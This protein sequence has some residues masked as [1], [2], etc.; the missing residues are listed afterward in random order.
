[1]NPK[2]CAAI[3]LLLLLFFQVGQAQTNPLAQPRL[4]SD[5]QKVLLWEEKTRFLV[6]VFLAPECPLCLTYAPVLR[7]LH[8]QTGT[9]RDIRFVG[10]FSGKNSD[11]KEIR[12]F[13]QEQEVPFPLIADPD[14]EIARHLGATIT[15]EVVVLGRNGKKI[16]QGRIDNRA[17]SLGKKRRVITAYDLQE[18][19]KSLQSGLVP[20]FRKTEA[21]GCFLE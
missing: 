4:S 11:P 9:Q 5:N 10:V 1:M 8:T 7:D 12:Q 15:P 18:V 19:L 14:K 6:L 16:Y 17:Y 13:Q 21:V 3:A 20:P 2:V